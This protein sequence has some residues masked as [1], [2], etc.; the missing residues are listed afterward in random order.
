VF[1]KHS[2][3][4]HRQP[5]KAATSRPLTT[6]VDSALAAHD[7]V[8]AAAGHPIPCFRRRSPNWSGSALGARPPSP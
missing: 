4:P 7:V 8:W 5:V 2:N 1:E 3:L 6:L